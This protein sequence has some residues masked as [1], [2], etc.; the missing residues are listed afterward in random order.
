MKDNAATLKLVAFRIH[1]NQE[2][3]IIADS[4]RLN[5]S[6]SE[7]VRRKLNGSEAK[8]IDTSGIL[9][10]ISKIVS[11]Q[12]RVNNNINQL[13]KHANT[14]RDRISLKLFQDHT[15]QMAKHLEYRDNM[16]KVLKQIYQAIK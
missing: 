10:A 16:N 13:A 4:K 6:K 3:Q 15:I 9:N 5:I 14:Y 1:P 11:E 2:A 8:I 7:L 12:A